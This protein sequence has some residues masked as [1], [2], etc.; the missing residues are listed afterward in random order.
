MFN[1]TFARGKALNSLGN[2]LPL[3]MIWFIFSNLKTPV[4]LLQ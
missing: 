3:L 4:D 2:L 1:F